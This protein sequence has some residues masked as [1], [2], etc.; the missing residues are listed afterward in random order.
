MLV[1][2]VQPRP[3]STWS[4]DTL[5]RVPQ[6]T[7]ASPQVLLPPII[8]NAGF[9]IKKRRFMAHLL[10]ILWLGIGCTLSST[11]A[12]AAAASGALRAMGLRHPWE[13]QSALALGAVAACSDTVAVLQVRVVRA[14]KCSGEVEGQ[15]MESQPGHSHRGK[16]WRG[17]A[18]HHPPIAQPH[19]PAVNAQ[20]VD[21]T[22]QPSLHSVL[23]GEGVVNDAV[24]IVLLGAVSGS[25]AG[26]RHAK[27]DVQLLCQLLLDCVRLSLASAALGVAVGLAGALLV[28]S[29]FARRHDCDREVWL[30]ADFPALFGTLSQDAHGTDVMHNLHALI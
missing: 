20:V 9:S 26:A 30:A 14:C 19:V 22:E 15:S 21:A 24:A 29:V 17:S 3:T 5:T 23:F 11:A 7:F 4:R 6:T 25:A 1:L 2:L 16:R 27:L 13:L 12:A 8:F 10:P 28:R 18:E